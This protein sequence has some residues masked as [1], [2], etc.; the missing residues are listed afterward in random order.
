MHSDYFCPTFSHLPSIPVRPVSSLEI[1]FPYSCLAVLCC[2]PL[3]LTRTIC[4]T[5]FELLE[6]SRLTSE[7]TAEDSDSPPASLCQRGW[8]G[9][10]NPS[11]FMTDCQQG[12]SGAGLVQVTAAA[13]NS[14]LHR[15]HHTQEMTFQGP[16]PRLPAS[17][18]FFLPPPPLPWRG[19]AL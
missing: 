10:R 3:T 5:G 16:S 13:V 1:Y 7:Y 12:Q 15:L 6:P 11:P 9:P 2:D 8:V 14:W 19:K 4:V 18:M 17:L